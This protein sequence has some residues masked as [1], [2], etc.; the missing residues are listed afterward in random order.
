MGS[1]GGSMGGFGGGSMGGFGGS[2]GGFGG[3]SMGS[4]GG[5]MGA[6]AAAASVAAAPDRVSTTPASRCSG[7]SYADR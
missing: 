1:F 4:L 7:R 2:M 5:S 3:G 6:L